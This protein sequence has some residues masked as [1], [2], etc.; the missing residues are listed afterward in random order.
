MPRDTRLSGGNK[1]ETNLILLEQLIDPLGASV[2][3][4]SEVTKF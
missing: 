1:K 3:I 4:L 2:I